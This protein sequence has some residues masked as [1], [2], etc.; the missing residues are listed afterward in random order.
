MIIT[1]TPLR[2]SFLGGGTDFPGFYREHGGCVLTTAID[3]YVYCIVKERFDKKVSTYASV[4]YEVFD[5]PSTDYHNELYS[6][7]HEKY[8]DLDTLDEKR[9]GIL[10]FDTNFLQN[11]KGLKKD[12]AWKGKEN[13][14]TLSTYIRNCIHHPDNGDTYK[15]EDLRKSIELLRS[16]L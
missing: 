1:Q 3:K 7:L 11:E 15:D 2:I 5:I 16:Y 8:Q 12:R 9:A 13:Q 14:A 4:T 10:N 6:K